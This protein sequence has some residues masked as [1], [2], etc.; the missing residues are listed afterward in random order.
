M[1][2]KTKLEHDRRKET[3][4]S[5]ESIGRLS[6]FCASRSRVAVVHSGKLCGMVSA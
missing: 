3:I 2:L 6:L 4:G 5:F 1:I